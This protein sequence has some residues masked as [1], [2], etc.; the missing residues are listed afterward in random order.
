M[1]HLSLLDSSYLCWI[2]CKRCGTTWVSKTLMSIGFFFV[3]TGLFPSFLHKSQSSSLGA[4][5]PKHFYIRSRSTNI[6]KASGGDDGSN[7]D[8]GNTNSDSDAKAKDIQVQGS[9]SRRKLSRTE[10]VAAKLGKSRESLTAQQEQVFEE[11]RLSNVKKYGLAFLSVFLAVTSV[12]I[13]KFDPNAGVTLLRYL[14]N[15]SAPIEV[16]GN[17]TPAVVEFSAAWCEN[18]KL[19]AKGIFDLENEYLSRVNF[20][21]LD[22]DDPKNQGV[23]DEYGVDGIPQL[24]LLD[25]DGKN[26]GSFVGRV[27]K[28]IL[29]DN[30]NA[31]LAGQKLPH[32]GFSSNDI[33]Q[34][35]IGK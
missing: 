25:G 12:L 5:R 21:V 32:P 28:T 30:L 18:C 27:P 29:S 11:A 9:A 7:T 14:Q 22:A 13:E 24:T 3:S 10:E 19:M 23:A 15:N 4:C 1:R 16:V 33:K 2:L 8:F 34:Q 31:I 6:V 17:G 26:L 20:V 35:T